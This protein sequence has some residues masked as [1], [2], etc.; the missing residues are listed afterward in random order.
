MEN[1]VTHVTE[2]VT[3]VASTLIT[4][5]VFFMLKRFKSIIATVERVEVFM[6][7]DVVEHRRNK[8]DHDLIFDHL[9]IPRYKINEARSR[10][11][12]VNGPGAV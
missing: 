3:A 6:E 10:I 4:W 8:A 7:K 12:R 5:A 9:N 2:V 11:G 1:A